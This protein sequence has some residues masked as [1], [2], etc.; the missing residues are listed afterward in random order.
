MSTNSAFTTMRYPTITRVFLV[1]LFISAVLWL[2]GTVM[3]AL[4][5]N[6]FFIPGTLEFDPKINISQERLLFQLVS[7]SSA[8]VVGAWAVALVSSIIV[9]RTIPLKVK[10]HGWLLMAAILFYTFVPAE[11]FTA[12]LDLHFIFDWLEAK[13][14][15]IANGP[16]AYYEYRI[17]L[18]ETLSHRIGALH[19][20]PVMAVLSYFTALAVIA[21]Q[22]IRKDAQADGE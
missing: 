5:A 13:S 11:I 18:R 19:G 22:P 21:W 10:E 4:I 16:G 3:R 15:Y 2:G 9:L 14:A 6:E 12:W 7:A 8:V 1:L 17:G 20:L